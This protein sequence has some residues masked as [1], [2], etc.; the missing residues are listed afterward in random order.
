MTL[1][2][3]DRLIREAPEG[4]S[5]I[6]YDI[7]RGDTGSKPKDM[8][9]KAGR[10]LGTISG[11]VFGGRGRNC[12][13]SVD[14]NRG[15]VNTV[16]YAAAA[17]LGG[18]RR[19]VLHH[20][21]RAHVDRALPLMRMLAKTAGPRAVHLCICPSMAA[22]LAQRYPAINHTTSMS[23]VISLDT[24]RPETRSALR[25]SHP[26]VWRLGHMSRM[27]MAK[28][29]GRAVETL[30]TLLE[31]GIPA[32]LSLAGSFSSQAD[33]D[34]AESAAERLGPALELVGPIF[35][36]EKTAWFRELDIFLFPS[37]Y[38]NETQGIVN[39]EALAVGTPV[40]AYGGHC[41]A[42]DLAGL[43]D[44]CLP[45]DADYPAEAL[46]FISRVKASEAGLTPLRAQAGERF[47]GLVANA[48]GAFGQ[49]VD[50]CF[51]ETE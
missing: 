22:N 27:N 16:A 17:R 6:A 50:F 18:A 4:V 9:I 32:R 21:T 23:N 24:D 8:L 14:A 5:V 34:F 42:D 19:I 37:L 26:E 40:L 30:E 1:H 12:Y 11:L 51:G 33:R 45:P 20:H 38:R 7:V 10:A 28:G 48:N 13:I 46:A 3:H 15:M 36:E 39:L 44:W 47:H 31:A 35:G 2:I 49:L 29:L 43:T 25:A 41:I